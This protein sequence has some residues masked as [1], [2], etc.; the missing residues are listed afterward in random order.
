MPRE[1][2][3]VTERTAMRYDSTRT[4]IVTFRSFNFEPTFRQREDDEA[5]NDRVLR[6]EHERAIEINK[7]SSRWEFRG[8]QKEQT[9]ACP[10]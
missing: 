5:A 8:E 3:R 9:M 10:A 7:M 1:T 4:A 2:P 6:R